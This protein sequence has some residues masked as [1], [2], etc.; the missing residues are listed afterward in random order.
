MKRK[1]LIIIFVFSGLLII[2]VFYVYHRYVEA[3]RKM[4]LYEKMRKNPPGEIKER[5]LSL[6]DGDIVFHKSLSA[7]SESIQLATHSEISHCGIVY[8]TENNFLVFEVSGT[9][10]ST[11]LI[12]WMGR[13]KGGK[14]EVK[15][16]KN[17]EDILSDSVL[18]KLKQ[19]GEKFVGKPY[20]PYFDWKDDQLYCS[21]LVWKVYKKATGLEIGHLKKLKD[22]DL[23][24]KKV[25]QAIKERYGTKTPSEQ[26]VISPA[27]IFESELLVDV[28]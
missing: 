4:A 14:F 23:S 7:Q 19:A 21:E 15:R 6:K 13:G 22:F 16:L 1:N 10:K 9:V 11:P 5:P 18:Q 25:K 27:A 24:D 28:E 12:E 20:D 17:A 2:A 26:P 3:K 8:K